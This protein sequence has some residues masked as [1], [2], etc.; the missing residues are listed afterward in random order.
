[1]EVGGYVLKETAARE[2]LPAIQA[3]VQGKQYVSKRLMDFGAIQ[4]A[5]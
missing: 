2:L 1:M 3:V 5:D 4:A